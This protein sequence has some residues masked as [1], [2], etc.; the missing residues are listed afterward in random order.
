[1]GCCHVTVGKGEGAR[2]GKI[3]WNL[4]TVMLVSVL[5]VLVIIAI[6]LD[7]LIALKTAEVCMYMEMPLCVMTMHMCIRYMPM[8]MY[9]ICV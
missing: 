6:Q 3:P 4:Q 9:C 2:V 5:I 1:M 8:Y 7:T